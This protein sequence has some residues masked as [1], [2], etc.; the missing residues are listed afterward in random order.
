MSID[1]QSPT[2]FVMAAQAAIHD[3]AP[4]LQCICGRSSVDAFLLPT[5]YARKQVV[6][7][8]RRGHDEISWNTNL[9]FMYQQPSCC[10]DVSSVDR[11]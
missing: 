7:G 11:L 9:Q 8:R 10:T 5:P 2:T 1:T 4:L 6:D 3:N